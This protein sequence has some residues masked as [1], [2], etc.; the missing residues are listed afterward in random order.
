MR[1]VADLAVFAV[2]AVIGTL[3]G[4]EEPGQ[5]SGIDGSLVI[6]GGGGLPD[7]VFAAFIELAGGED[8]RIVVVPTASTRADRDDAEQTY[9]RSWIERGVKE[10]VLLHTRS[11][12]EADS[13]EFCA[14][15]RRATGV[16][17]SG[18]FSIRFLPWASRS[19]PRLRTPS[20][21][22]RASRSP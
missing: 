21:C 3:S 7:E 10:P 17:F 8:A 18:A 12:E 14:V 1:P 16:W 19:I 11:R 6:G 20:D 2:L 22:L 4:Q 15:L 5:K 9:L 13:E